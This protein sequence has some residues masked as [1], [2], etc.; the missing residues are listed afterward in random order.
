M[1]HTLVVRFAEITLKGRNRGLFE[2]Q[3]I[4][5]VEAHLRPY[6]AHR[7]QRGTARLLVEVEDDPHTAIEILRGL[8]GVANLSLAEFAPREPEPLAEAVLAHVGR[9]LGA[10]RREAS[11]PSAERPLAFRVVVSRKDKRYPL[12]SMELAARL[13]EAL[14]RRFEGLRVDLTHPE[15]TVWVEI[16]EDRAAIYADK[17]AGPGGLAVGSSGKVLC[18]FSGGIDS[19]VAAYLMM[20]RGAPVV[21]LNFH[22]FPYI[23][24]RSKEKVHELARHLA[25]FQPKSRL[26][27]APF[28]KTQEAI[29]DRCPE[30]LRTVLYRRMMNRVANRLAAREGALALVTGESLGQVASQTL[31]NIRVIAE[32]A[33]L[34]V[35]QPLIG[36]SKTEII[37]IARRIG[38]YPISIQ[39]Y[40][41]CCTLFQPRHPDT[42]AKPDRAAHFEAALDIEALVEEC[43][44]SVEVTDYGP[45]YSPRG[46]S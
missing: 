24:E 34:P 35:L 27:V 12:T 37:A 32:T 19:P 42:H 18:L 4:R 43:V 1:A 31:H 7:L 40:P 20:T 26:C 21:F 14:L 23:G 36:M 13:G 11:P 44:A 16:W 33:E 8:P 30:G 38:T 17:I 28:A 5:N 6:V 9:Q 10:R 25:R 29:R 2:Q 15:L 39:P 45:L 3:L 22:S 41:D 46:W